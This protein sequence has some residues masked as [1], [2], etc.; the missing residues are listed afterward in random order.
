[1]PTGSG[2]ATDEAE[3]YDPAT[4]AIVQVGNMTAAGGRFHHTATYLDP[5]IVGSGSLAGKVLITGGND[6]AGIP[7]ASAEY[8]D[9]ATQTF[10]AL[11]SMNYVRASQTAT[12]LTGGPNA[13]KVLITGGKRSAPPFGGVNPTVCDTGTNDG[14]NANG[15]NTCAELFDPSTATFT[16]ISGAMTTGREFHTAVAITQGPNAG[17]VLLAGGDDGASA[18]SS[19]EIYD[20]VSFTSV[21]PLSTAR[22][23]LSGTLLNTG[24]EVL[25]AGGASVFGT[26][27]VLEPG[28]T[29]VLSSADTSIVST[30][31]PTTGPMGSVRENQTGVLITGGTDSGD[32]FIAG[33]DTDNTAT[34]TVLSSTELFVPSSDSFTAGPSMSVARRYHTATYLDPA[35]VSGSNAGKV[36][37]IGGESAPGNANILNSID[38]LPP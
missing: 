36:L 15:V 37:I 17:E 10:T 16:L 29:S 18:L 32:V 11:A 22:D 26:Y 20:G 24:S 21:A 34:P 3:V 23:Y 33:G 14:V 7:Q 1:V 12:L 5:S 9:P 8:Y 4:N 27:D 35:L 38:L 6:N 2:G 13:G 19:A 31:S 30:T 25:F 28:G